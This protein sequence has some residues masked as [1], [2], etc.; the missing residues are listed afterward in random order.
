M[1]SAWIPALC[2]FAGTLVGAVASAAG[3]LVAQ[4]EATKREH[5]SE[6]VKAG[7]KQWEVLHRDL[8][9]GLAGS[10]FY[11]PEV[12]VMNLVQLAPL[13]AKADKIPNKILVKEFR[14]KIAKIDLVCDE[15]KINH[16]VREAVAEG[17][18]CKWSP[19]V[20]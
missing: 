3:V 1:E 10:D 8:V 9:D 20:K 16:S 19:R 6:L 13:L 15:V 14:A 12:Y 4:R 18:A 11:P 5:V 7:M 2:G 17:R